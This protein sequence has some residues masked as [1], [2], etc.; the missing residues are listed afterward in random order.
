MRPLIFAG[1]RSRMLVLVLLA[2]LPALGLILHNAG[3]QR[4]LAGSQAEQDVFRLVRLATDNYKHLTKEAE[5]LLVIMAQSPEVWADDLTGY[6]QVLA[7]LTADYP[8]YAFVGLNKA[9]GMLTVSDSEAFQPFAR[10]ARYT[11]QQAVLSGGFAGGGYAVDPATGRAVA[12]F[13]YP[14]VVTGGN[15]AAVLFTAVDLK[16]LCEFAAEAGIHESIALVLVD[17]NGTILSHYPASQWVGQTLPD[18]PVV[19]EILKRQTEDIFEKEGLN[20]EPCCNAFS[21]LPAAQGTVK[22]YVCAGIPT[23]VIQKEVDAQVARNLQHLGLVAGLV[24]VIAGVGGE[25]FLMRGVEALVNATKR[26]AGGDWQTRTNVPYTTGEIGQLAR[27]F[28]EMAATLE[29]STHRL[30][31]VLDGLPGFVYLQGRDY[32]IRFAN[33]YFRECFGDPAGQPCYRIFHQQQEPCPVCPNF[34]VFST[35]CFQTWERQRFDGRVYQL[36]NY[37]FEDLDGSLLVLTLGIDI[38]ESKHLA[39][40]L[41][42]LERLQLVGKLAAGIGHEIRNPLTTVQGFLQLLGRKPEYQADR[43]H[44]ELMIE[45]LDRANEIIG[46]FLT[47]ARD[48]VVDLQPRNLSEIV[49]ALFPLLQADARN[50]QQEV[51]LNLAVVPA[52]LLDEKELRQ[53]LH[54]LARNGLEAMSP[55]GVLTIST[56]AE[57]DAV[58]LAVQDQGPG[59]PVEVLPNLGTPFF[60]T[61]EQGTGLGLLVCYNIAARHNAVISVNTGAKGTTLIIRFPRQVV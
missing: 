29:Q 39:K 59:I 27:A 20:G 58:T 15:S 31:S 22:A 5:Q 61:K 7:G 56:T 32:T 21:P 11:C 48:R 4:R 19:K 23:A 50:R 54:N 33:R 53:L 51:R 38:T 40:E 13:S 24:L 44:F 55:G 60:T 34:R 28:D 45:E 49:E 10:V 14:V 57:E 46:E 30:F 6:R 35:K 36:Y 18:A 37:P 2:V 52:A 16:W 1:L 26:L 17:E 25:L 43:P 42:Q 47:L 3:E 41:E 9:D 8:N 12:I